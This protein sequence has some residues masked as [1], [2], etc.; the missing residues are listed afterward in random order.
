MTSGTTKVRHCKYQSLFGSLALLLA[1]LT[2]LLFPAIL[3][4]AQSNSP[5]NLKPTVILISIDGFRFDYPEKAETPNLH[6]VIASGVRA[7]GLIPQFPTLTFPNHYAIVTG[8]LP[9]HNGIVANTMYDPALHALF[10]MTDHAQVTD[11][12]WWGGEPIWVTAEKQGQ[13]A[14]TM[15]WPGSEAEIEGIHPTYWLPY[16]KEKSNA[17]RV[18]QVL[19][20]L[21]LPAS[22]RPTLLTLY[23]DEVDHAGHDHGP[24]STEVNNAIRDVDTAIGL[25]MRCISDNN[26]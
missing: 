15:F 19:D 1:V 26:M 23:F 14:A 21:D 11:S 8:L 3:L 17:E 18:K 5:A 2:T 22:Q 20:W 12:R 4:V 24:N 16:D 25:L 9:A 10:K 7:D 6:S 13:K